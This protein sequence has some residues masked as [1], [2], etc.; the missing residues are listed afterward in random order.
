M[1]LF[2]TGA[3]GSLGSKTVELLLKEQH[4]IHA[5]IKDKKKSKNLKEIGV[6]PIIGDIFDKDFMITSTKGFDGFIQ[7]ASAV[8]R[9]FNTKS[10]DWKDEIKLKK[11][12]VKNSVRAVRT[13]KIPFYIQN[14]S[15]LGYGHRGD[16]WVDE[17]I[18]LIYPI[19]TYLDLDQEYLDA[20][21]SIIKSEYILN[22]VFDNQFPRIILR[23]GLIYGPTSFHTKELIEQV[24]KNVFP[25]IETGDSF[26]NLIH[27]NDAASAIVQSVKNHDKLLLRTFNVSDDKPVLYK[28]LIDNLAK[29]LS[30]KSPKRVPLKLGNTLVGR[31]EANILL[32]SVKS[33]NDKFK[34]FTGWKPKYSTF[35]EGIDAVLK[36]LNVKN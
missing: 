28:D 22:T 15:L 16:K 35:S 20:L 6:N 23:F 9:K 25:V 1:K 19:K 5:L 2:V 18:R 8:P 24:Q 29:K 14:T 11:E 7:L 13:N 33:K 34:R 12:G 10:K 4:E 21:E 36:S 26:L 31:F 17:S 27:V 32:S 30:A 3:T